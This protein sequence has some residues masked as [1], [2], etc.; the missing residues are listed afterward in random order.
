VTVQLADRGPSEL[1]VALLSI[2]HLWRP[3]KGSCHTIDWSEPTEAV[4]ATRFKAYDRGVGYEELILLNKR[5]QKACETI[6]KPGPTNFTKHFRRAVV[7]D[8]R[9]AAKIS[10]NV[11]P[12]DTTEVTAIFV[13][14]QKTLKI[15]ETEFVDAADVATNLLAGEKR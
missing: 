14:T 2:A 8:G 13:D 3:A 10:A 9:Q 12:V 15:G 7:S 6:R 4:V 11:G 5:A 1:E